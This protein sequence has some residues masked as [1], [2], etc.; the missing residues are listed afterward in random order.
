[1]KKRRYAH[2]YKHRYAS[3]ANQWSVHRWISF[4]HQ[5]RTWI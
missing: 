3:R 5:N 2:A 1:M 4:I